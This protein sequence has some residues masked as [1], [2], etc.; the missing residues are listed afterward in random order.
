MII[1]FIEGDGKKTD[2]FRNIYYQTRFTA[3]HYG[4]ETNG[5][6]NEP[7]NRFIIP[8]TL[9]MNGEQMENEVIIIDLEE[10]VSLGELF[11]DA[12]ENALRFFP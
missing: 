11:K 5:S 7:M 4:K 1:L 3:V 10:D 12:I 8:L 6:F 2:F 9:K